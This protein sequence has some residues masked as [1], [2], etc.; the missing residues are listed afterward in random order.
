M[1]N[2]E[3]SNEVVEDKYKLTRYKYGRQSFKAGKV[4]FLPSI[5]SNNSK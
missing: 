5:D 1:L 3:L 2:D 4:T